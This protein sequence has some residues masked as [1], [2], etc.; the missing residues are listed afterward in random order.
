MDIY[1]TIRDL[2]PAISESCSD[3][4]RNEI[5][6]EIAAAGDRIGE[7]VVSVFSDQNRIQPQ[8]HQHPGKV[9]VKAMMWEVDR[10]VRSSALALG[11]I[12]ALTTRIDPLVGDLLSALQASDIGIGEAILTALKGVIKHAAKSVSSASRTLIVDALYYNPSFTLSILQKLGVATEIFN[13]WFHMLQQTKKSG[14]RANSKREHEKKVYCLG[15]TSLLSLPADQM[16][17]AA[18]EGIFLRPFLTSLYASKEQLAEAAKGEDAEDEV[19]MDGFRS[20]DDDN[21]SDREMADDDE[22]GDEADSLK[23]QKLAAKASAFRSN[24]DED[25]SS[26]DDFCDDEELQSAIDEADPFVFFVDSVK[27]LVGS[28]DKG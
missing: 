25:D 22:D 8:S 3:V 20:D 1:E 11:K 26:D 5:T 14:A 12:S 28:A 24:D 2:I 4:C 7:A 23:L 10:T 6:H 18:F 19:E 27:V 21:E 15:L 16:P 13:L 17:A 9:E